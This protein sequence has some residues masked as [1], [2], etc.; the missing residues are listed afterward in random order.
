MKIDLIEQRVIEAC[1]L[2][3]VIRAFG[4]KIGIDA[5]KALVQKTHE[6][7]SHQYGAA[8][9][10][11]LGSN[12]MADLAQIV[13]GWANGGALEEEIIEL[14]SRTYAFNVVRCRYAERYH[15]LGLGEFG[16]CLSCCR[17]EPFVKGFNKNIRF[18]RDQTIMEGASHCDFRFT[19]EPGS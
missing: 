13:R 5:A 9:A 1:A 7:S 3:P 2:V 16:Y 11:Q 19:L 6:A 8:C 15:E 12:S 10:E 17:D 14:T 4:E 18:Q